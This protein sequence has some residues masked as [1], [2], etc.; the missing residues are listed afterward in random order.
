ME[1][2]RKPKKKIVIQYEGQELELNAPSVMAF[3]AVEESN[4]S[5][6]S[7][8]KFMKEMGLS[9]D[10]YRYWDVNDCSEFFKLIVEESLKKSPAVSPSKPVA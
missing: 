5:M 4:A 10:I 8:V 2:V 3:A 9:E 6:S 1:F 7:I